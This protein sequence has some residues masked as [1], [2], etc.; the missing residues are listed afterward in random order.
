MNSSLI[1][2]E[3]DVKDAKNKENKVKS[4]KNKKESSSTTISKKSNENNLAK[5]FLNIY[6]DI[7]LNNFG[8][9]MENDFDVNFP[10]FLLIVHKLG[11]TNKNFAILVNELG[12]ELDKT[13][14]LKEFS[15]FASNSDISI[16]QLSK[17]NLSLSKTKNCINKLK[18]DTEFQL[19]MDA[20][21]IITEKQIFDEDISL[22]SKKIFIFLLVF[23]VYAK[24][25]KMIK[26]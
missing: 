17:S 3:K 5:K 22:S 11:F 24:K 26:L 12:S 9:K 15:S 6:K 16:S 21:K 4:E 7:L 10:G 13:E 8:Q 20:W 25:K 18:N 2:E 1:H 14:H 19:C 23:W